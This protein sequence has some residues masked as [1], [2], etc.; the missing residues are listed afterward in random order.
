[1]RSL[2]KRLRRKNKPEIDPMA[3]EEEIKTLVSSNDVVLFM[4]GTAQAPQCGFSQRAVQILQACGA[5]FASV[6][7][8]ENEGIRQG[9]KTFSDWPTIPQLY[10]RGEFVGG[11]DI[12]LEMYQSGDLA[13]TLAAPEA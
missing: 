6:N 4:K 10:V 8:L 2:L 7:V 12:M 11:S 9:I 5:T 3:I 13:K 1:M